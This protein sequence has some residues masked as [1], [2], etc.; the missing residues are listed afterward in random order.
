VKETLN[1]RQKKVL[2]LNSQG[3]KPQ[4]IA[5]ILNITVK[6]AKDALSRGK[7]NLDKIIENIGFAIKHNLLDD[8]QV[9]ALKNTLNAL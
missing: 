7:N 1:E 9:G 4:E 5:E 3:K 2:S 8:R 6:G